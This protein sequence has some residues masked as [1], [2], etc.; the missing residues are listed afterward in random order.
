[1]SNNTT[2]TYAAALYGEKA[3]TCEYPTEARLGIARK[4]KR[5]VCVP[6]KD[7]SF[8]DLQRM[9]DLHTHMANFTINIKSHMCYASKVA[10]DTCHLVCTC[11]YTES[12][13]RCIFTSIM[14]I[15]LSRYQDGMCHI[16]KKCLL[17]HFSLQAARTIFLGLKGSYFHS[18]ALFAPGKGTFSWKVVFT[19]FILIRTILRHNNSMCISF[20]DGGYRDVNGWANYGTRELTFNE[21]CENW[22]RPL[23]TRN[24]VFL[25]DKFYR[26]LRC[27]CIPD[28]KQLLHYSLCEC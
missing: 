8:L 5:R 16:S 18:W 26:D 24:N 20:C 14:C 2:I 28:L 12:T 4:L 25:T 9:Y 19:I 7:A 10:S 15:P 17:H 3:K 1:M 21:I 22:S 23:T 27:L 13:L 11:I 6:E